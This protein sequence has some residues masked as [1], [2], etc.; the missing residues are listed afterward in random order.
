MAS[1]TDSIAVVLKIKPVIY[2]SFWQAIKMRISGAYRNISDI[3]T[4][5]EVTR[6]TYDK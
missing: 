3:E 5:G 2:I 6:I 1:V 4:V